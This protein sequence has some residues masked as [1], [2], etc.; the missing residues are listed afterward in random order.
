MSLVALQTSNLEGQFFE[1]LN[2]QLR[3]NH[4]WPFVTFSTVASCGLSAF[5][6]YNML[7]E[8]RS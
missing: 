4:E 5:V 2:L 3:I 8:D 7:S 1:A 6:V